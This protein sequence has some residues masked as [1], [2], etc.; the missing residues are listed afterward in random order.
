MS[1]SPMLA[2]YDHQQYLSLAGYPTHLIRRGHG[3]R[4]AFTQDI[5][6]RVPFPRSFGSDV[7]CSSRTRHSRSSAERR[8][9]WEGPHF[10]LLSFFL[11]YFFYLLRRSQGREESG[12]RTG[13]KLF[14]FWHHIDL[15]LF[16][17][18]SF[19]PFVS[20]TDQACNWSLFFFTLFGPVTTLAR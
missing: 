17:S 3:D 4:P 10:N 15:S 9:S 11:L 1:F 14:G 20:S 19:L 12:V 13:K 7:I 6:F 2:V 8:R 18:L 5:H 16:F